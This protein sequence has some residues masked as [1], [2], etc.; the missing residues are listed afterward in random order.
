MS[1]SIRADA[2][3]K[4]KPGNFGSDGEKIASPLSTGP[5]REPLPFRQVL[6]NAN[7][8]GK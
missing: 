3:E 2:T 6:K 5:V 1:A 4:L 8:D 7:A